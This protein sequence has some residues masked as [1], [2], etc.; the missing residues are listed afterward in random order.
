MTF[1]EGEI[2]C[3]DHPFLTRKWV[4]IVSRN[5]RNEYTHMCMCTCVHT[6]LLDIHTSQKRQP[7]ILSCVDCEAYVAPLLLNHLW[8]HIHTRTHA[9]GFLIRFL[10]CTSSSYS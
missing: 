1:F 8:P 4:S 7:A 5:A 6:V 2:I 9:P 10:T 3:K